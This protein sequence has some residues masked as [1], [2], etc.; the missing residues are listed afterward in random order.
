MCCLHIA[1][2]CVEAMT[3]ANDITE[4][5]AEE[6]PSTGVSDITDM[7]LYDCLW[8]YIMSYIVEQNYSF[9]HMYN[10]VVLKI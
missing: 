2:S 3:E 8:T 10:I 7:H 9:L 4:C 6:Q 5:S 1:V